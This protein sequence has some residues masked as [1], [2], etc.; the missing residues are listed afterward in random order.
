MYG[1]DG[2]AEITGPEDHPDVNFYNGCIYNKDYSNLIYYPSAKEYSE[3]LLHEN[4]T[5]FGNYAFVQNKKLE[6][7]TIPLNVNVLGTWLFYNTSMTKLTVHEN[8]QSIG[9]QCFS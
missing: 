6:E 1:F 2:L 3:N 7:I 4:V 9:S 5:S 8:V